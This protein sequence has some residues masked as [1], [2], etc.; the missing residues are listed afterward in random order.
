VKTATTPLLHL[1]INVQA[2]STSIG[3]GRQ[4]MGE[5]TLDEMR[6]MKTMRQRKIIMKE[7]GFFSLS[8]HA[9]FISK[10]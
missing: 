1:R 3:H 6:K 4:M 8:Q 10:L 5:K 9:L 2:R 7:L